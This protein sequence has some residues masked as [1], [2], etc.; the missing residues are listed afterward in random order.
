MP[1]CIPYSFSLEANW[2]YP[3]SL[4]GTAPLPSSSPSAAFLSARNS[5]PPPPSCLPTPYPLPAEPY[6]S[7][8]LKECA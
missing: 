5:L 4:A 1:K 8:F 7:S 6:S 2:N 3:G